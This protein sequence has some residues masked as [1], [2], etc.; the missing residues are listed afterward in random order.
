V[1]YY[2]TVPG[3]EEDFWSRAETLVLAA[4]ADYA[5]QAQGLEAS[6]R[7]MF[8]QDAS[9]GFAFIDLVRKRF[10]VAL[11]NPPFGEFTASAKPYAKHAFAITSNN[12]FA[13]STQ[14]LSD[15]LHDRGLPGAITSRTGFFITNFRRWREEF[16]L[17]RTT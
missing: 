7:R 5:H 11:M 8:A 17:D 14:R 16:L 9:R 4:L 15:M 10:D 1:K 13:A 3:E 2:K 12:I 6:R